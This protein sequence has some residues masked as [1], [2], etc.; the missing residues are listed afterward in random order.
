MRGDV[1]TEVTIRGGGLGLEQGLE[2]TSFYPRR[3]VRP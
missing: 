3:A 1:T 2:L